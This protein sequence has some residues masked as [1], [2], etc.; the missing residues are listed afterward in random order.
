MNWPKF[1]EL[2]LYIAWSSENDPRF[3]AVKL[4][5][6]LYYSDFAAYRRLGRSITEATYQHLEE[7]PAPREMLPAQRDMVDAGDL[8]IES[9][10][11]FGRPQ[12][13]P[14]ALRDPGGN[15]GLLS[16]AEL[17]IVDEVMRD[18]LLLDA[19]VVADRSHREFGYQTT[20]LREEIPY[21]TAWIG[22]DPLTAE[23]IEVG[24]EVARR[25]G[26]VGAAG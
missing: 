22:S 11:Y 26:L 16:A 8:T 14:K 23:Q 9:R 25:H 3:G 15:L 24:L 17:E 1:K 6:I 10:P 7:G 12:R 5:K 20:N 13:R 19:T 4:N 2:V 21:Y 18:L